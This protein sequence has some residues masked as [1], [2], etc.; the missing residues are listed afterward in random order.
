[1]EVMSILQV[2]FDVIVLAD[3]FGFLLLKNAVGAVLSKKVTVE[4][5]LKFLPPAE[6]YSIDC[7]Q[8]KCLNLIEK[9]PVAILSSEEFLSFNPVLIKM[10]LSRDTFEAPEI[11]IF[12]CLLRVIRTQN[13]ED[14]DAKEL[15]QSCIRLSS[16]EIKDIFGLVEPAGYFSETVILQ[17]MKA[18]T[19]HD[20]NHI[21]GRGAKGRWT[22]FDI[23]IEGCS[24][25]CCKREYPVYSL[26]CIIYCIL[27]LT[28]SAPT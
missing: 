27:P 8:E 12:E 16:I 17:S 6:T 23:Y 1:M 24:K 18:H 10:I 9:A 2:M 20:L 14:S 4:N 22:V 26:V 25:S 3:R 5:A 7:L 19:Q 28:L 11:Q 13:L 21:Q 15:L